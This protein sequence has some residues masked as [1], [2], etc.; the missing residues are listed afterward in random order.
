MLIDFAPAIWY[1]CFGD[2]MKK[3]KEEI[4]GILVLIGYLLLSTLGQEILLLLGVNRLPTPLKLIVALIYDL[5][6]LMTIIFIYLKTIVQD[7][8]QFKSNIKYYIDNYFKYFFLNLGLMMIS[9]II[10]I[11]ITS[12]NNS[13]NQEYI[14]SMLGKHPLYTI[15]ATILIAPIT[16]ELMFRLNIRKIF[17]SDLLFIIMSGLIFGALHLTVATSFKE[18]L[19]IIPYSIPGFIFA[20]TLT[21]SK[22]IFVP[23]SL[24]TMH[25]TL[26]ILLQLLLTLK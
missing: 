25:N 1:N 22:N 14:T 6:I 9:N 3:Y 8:N 15:I 17:K 18:L 13:T 16:E 20:Y 10:I 19:F 2:N 26:M 24:H 7:F 11:N 23:I 12:I 21:K 4:I 5:F